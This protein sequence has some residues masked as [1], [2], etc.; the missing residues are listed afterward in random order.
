MAEHTPLPWVRDRWGQPKPPHGNDNL[1]HRET[2][3]LD[4]FALST[5]LR[6]PEAEENSKIVLACVNAFAG[7][8]IPTEKIEPGLFWEMRD[9]LSGIVAD[10][11]EGDFVS[12]EQ[13]ARHAGKAALA[14]ARG[15]Q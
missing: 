9:A 15:S 10:L 2:V 5:G 14:K 4:G 8:E 6:N 1:E 11:L 7:R 13:I 3:A 12:A